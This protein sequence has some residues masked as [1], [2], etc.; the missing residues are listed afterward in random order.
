MVTNGYLL[1]FAAA[2]LGCVLATPLV[3]RLAGWAGAIDRPDQFRRIHK[4]AIPRLGG[5][6]LAVGLAL[7]L[8]PAVLWGGVERW[9]GV[10]AWWGEQWAVVLASLVVLALGA[11][12]DTRGVSPRPKLLGQSLAICILMAGGIRIKQFSLLG[13]PVELTYTLPI[14][15]LGQTLSLD[16]PSLLVTWIWFLACMNIWNL[17]DGM[18]GLA[19]GVGLLV[20]GTLMLVAMRTGNSADS[21]ALAAALAGSL[22]GFLLYNWHPA[23]IFLG[24]SGSLLLG[25]LIGVIGV[26]SSMK[27]TTTVSI[28]FPIL[29]MGLPVSDTA[30]AIFRRWARELPLS[31]A[32]RRHVHHLLIGL[33]LGPRQAALFLYCFSGF[34]C[35]VVLL[36]VTLSNSAHGEFFAL[37]V[38]LSGVLAFLLILTSRRDELACLMRD[39]KARGLRKKQERR[40]RAATWDAI[41][42]IELCA[43]PGG[44]WDVLLQ[45]GADLG[46]GHL[47]VCCARDD[48]IVFQRGGRTGPLALGLSGTTA[49]LRL[50]GADGLEIEVNLREAVGSTT[51]V[52]IAFRSLQRLALATV[53]RLDRLEQDARDAA[54]R[55]QPEP[56]AP[57]SARPHRP[58]PGRELT[59]ETPA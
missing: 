49:S 55:P 34:L 54:D 44:V 11:L 40:A 10:A 13:L 22:A 20:S 47:E 32:D 19:S 5:V 18:D 29:A 58:R 31:A 52:D 57:A 2:F 9:E 35:G 28:L 8:V 39:L 15:V 56:T 21:A 36:G 17:I 1:V 45:A 33:G 6:G 50:L 37:L 7:A 24:D 51:P 59:R 30:M 42:R 53:E 46:C 41:Q 16:L 25:L 43:E 4:G 48:Q 26:Q 14:T 38:G 27:G 12:D 23:C 3:T